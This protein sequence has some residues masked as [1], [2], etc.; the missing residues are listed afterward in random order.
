MAKK[1]FAKKASRSAAQKK[2]ISTQATRRFRYY[3][4]MS[5]DGFIADPNGGVAWLDPYGDGDHGMAT[6]WSEI[7]TLVMGRKTF[8]VALSFGPWP[9]E[10]TRTI[11]LSSRPMVDLPKGVEVA[12][13]VVTLVK[14]LRAS[15][16][17]D[18]WMMGGGV[19]AQ[20]F[21]QMDV[22]DEIG[23]SIIPLVLGEG[24]PLFAPSQT[25]HALKLIKSKSFS[26]GMVQAIYEPVRRSPSTSAPRVS[27]KSR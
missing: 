12:S 19:T 13:D 18:I 14:S 22:L 8:E 3:A 9:H 11:V 25:T 17:K 5:L 6:F 16:G 27:S 21:L 7:D 4:A 15:K 2:G 20:S 26:N 23:L 1:Q 10:K 24:I